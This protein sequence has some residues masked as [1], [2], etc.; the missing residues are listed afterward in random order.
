MKDKA[1]WRSQSRP[2]R[3]YKIFS[4]RKIL[5]FTILKWGK[6]GDITRTR[7]PRSGVYLGVFVDITSTNRQR[8]KL[9]LQFAATFEYIKTPALRRGLCL[10]N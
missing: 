7:N 3:N 4:I 2:F 9:P 6:R 8:R 1:H 10:R 5:P